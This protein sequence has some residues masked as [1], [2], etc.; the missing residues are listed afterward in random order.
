MH[1]MEQE[2]Y[3]QT[4][5]YDPGT[6]KLRLH[7]K[8]ILLKKNMHMEEFRLCCDQRFQQVHQFENGKEAE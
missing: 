7:H 8:D 2:W 5:R 4:F 3:L 1:L 6:I